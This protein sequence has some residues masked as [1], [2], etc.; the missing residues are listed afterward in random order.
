MECQT[1]FSGGKTE[2]A[3]KYSKMLSAEIFTP[4]DWHRTHQKKCATTADSSYKIL[5][6][7]ISN[8][9]LS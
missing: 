8:N 2:I 1:I 9:R 6:S 3:R 5:N 4:P 7:L